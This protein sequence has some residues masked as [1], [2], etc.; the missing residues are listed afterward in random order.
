MDEANRIAVRPQPEPMVISSAVASNPAQQARGIVVPLYQLDPSVN[1]P[2]ESIPPFDSVL[3]GIDEIYNTLIKSRNGVSLS[4]A[5]NRLYFDYKFPS[6]RDGT[7]GCHK[8]PAEEFLH[9]YSAALLEA[10]DRSKYGNHELYAGLQE[11]AQ[12]ELRP[13]AY[14][15]AD[16][17]LTL[18]PRQSQPRGPRK[19]PL[20]PATPVSGNEDSP[21]ASDVPAPRGKRPG[22][23]RGAK[24]SLRPITPAP[25]KRPRSQFETDSEQESPDIRKSYYFSDDDDDDDTMADAPDL[26]SDGEDDNEIDDPNDDSTSSRYDLEPI[27]LV[28]RAEKIPSSSPRGP[29]DTWTCDEDDCGYIVRGGDQAEC[30]ERIRQHF[31]DHEQQMTRVSLAVTEGSRGHMPIK[32][33]YFPPFLIQV[34]I[35]SPYHPPHVSNHQRH[36]LSS[37]PVTCPNNTSETA[38][39]STSLSTPLSAPSPP[40][41]P[42]PPDLSGPAQDNF[43]ALVERFRRHPHPVSDRI[44]SLIML[45]SLARKAQPN[46]SEENETGQQ[47]QRGACPADQEEINSVTV[48]GDYLA[49]YE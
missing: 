21:L 23:P 10:L 12:T 31:R 20:A 41:P 44:D 2:E 11:M 40:T 47:Q 42:Q 38:L 3:R 7:V 33:A 46:E 16:F 26:Q 14:K 48:C 39:S 35:K 19:N 24:S 1:W 6:Y 36:N 9:Y 22:R 45:Q 29:N 49:S 13:V 32:Y 43:R 28:I 17:P 27:K 25:R 30:Q 15:P 4:G 8:K 5:L 37:T 18:L 34:F